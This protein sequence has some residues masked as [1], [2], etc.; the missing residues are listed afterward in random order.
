MELEVKIFYEDK[1]YQLEVYPFNGN[2]ISASH[3]E[4][5]DILE[6]IIKV[7]ERLLNK[8]NISEATF[9]FIVT[10]TVKKKNFK[11]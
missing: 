10:V 8:I 9:I 6:D 7:V 3:F 5:K 1:G 11:Y 4:L 2:S